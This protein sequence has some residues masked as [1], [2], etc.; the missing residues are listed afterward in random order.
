MR[1]R[2]SIQTFLLIV[3]IMLALGI[4]ASAQTYYG[5][6]AGNNNQQ[7]LDGVIISYTPDAETNRTYTQ[8]DATDSLVYFTFGYDDIIDVYNY[9]GDFQF[10]LIFTSKRAN[11]RLVAKCEGNKLL[12]ITKNDEY[13]EFE[14]DSLINQISNYHGERQ[15][16]FMD[17]IR[18]WADRKCI[19]T[20]DENG[21]WEVF[22]P[23]PD[24]AQK[25]IPLI[26]VSPE[27]QIIL[28]WIKII[29]FIILFVFVGYF[30]IV[31][32]TKGVFFWQMRHRK[33]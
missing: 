32:R 10:C 1:V 15:E 8:C 18:F 26:P 13:Y 19:Y 11:G 33:D 7:V 17:E 21:N 25:H 14:G 29:C 23:T 28:N 27:N 9:N 31:K 24:L 3:L 16:S 5:S 2:Y 6:E 4:S 20:R 12:V 30:I 22:L